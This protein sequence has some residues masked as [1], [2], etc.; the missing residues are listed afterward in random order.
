MASTMAL[1][2]GA[3]VHTSVPQHVQTHTHKYIHIPPHIHRYTKKE[4]IHKIIKTFASHKSNKTLTQNT[5]EIW[6]CSLYP[7]TFIN[8]STRAF[9]TSL[10]TANHA[11]DPRTLEAE[12]G[13]VKTSLGCTAQ[14]FL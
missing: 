6:Q 5:K 11:Y 10:G 12:D 2:I 1:H 14:D 8:P 9:R 4:K 13:G 3:L 7:Y